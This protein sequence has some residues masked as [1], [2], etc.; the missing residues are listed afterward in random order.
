MNKEERQERRKK[1]ICDMVDFAIRTY[2]DCDSD[3]VV[4][5]SLGEDFKGH[6]YFH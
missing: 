6:V 1:K 3:F 2:Y 5:L 4:C